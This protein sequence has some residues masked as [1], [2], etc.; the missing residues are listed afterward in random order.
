ME[1]GL[2]PDPS[3]LGCRVEKLLEKVL[4]L[5]AS[6]LG[7]LVVRAG[8]SE[9]VTAE[10]ENEEAATV[11]GGLVALLDGITDAVVRLLSCSGTILVVWI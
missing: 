6:I 8:A 2:E 7:C 10:V 5:D 4:G 11:G 1:N 9:V 3:I